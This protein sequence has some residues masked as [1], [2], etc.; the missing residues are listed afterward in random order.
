MIQRA[1]N[2]KA[3][4]MIQVDGLGNVLDGMYAAD[5]EE[6]AKDPKYKDELYAMLPL[7][8]V[9]LVLHIEDEPLEVIFAK[10]FK[11]MEPIAG[12]WKVKWELSDEARVILEEKWSV[13]AEARF[14]DFLDYVKNQVKELHNFNLNFK[15]FDRNKL[16]VI[17]DS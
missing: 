7:E 15:R 9:P 5:L 13:T 3:G 16:F 6:L 1:K 10:A 4:R 11:E 2:I 12:K 17:S 14:D 8:S